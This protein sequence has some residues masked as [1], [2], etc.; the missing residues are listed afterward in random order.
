M[1]T[2]ASSPRWTI[3]LASSSAAAA[4][5]QKMQPG[6]SAPPPTYSIRH[7]AHRRSVT[8]LNPPLV[9]EE[10]HHADGDRQHD[11]DR[12]DERVVVVLER[13]VVEVHP[14]DA[15]H[16]SERE[17]DHRE[18]REQPQDVVLLVGD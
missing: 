18:D 3:R 9:V 6:A 14:K 15:G 16:E 1:R 2:Y 7:G 10:R 8:G 13:D 12:H 17:Q 5:S 11:P 4:L